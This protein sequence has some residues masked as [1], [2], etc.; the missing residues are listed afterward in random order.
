MRFHLAQRLSLALAALKAASAATVYLAGDS[1]MTANGNNDGTAGWGKFLSDY[2]SLTVVNNAIAGRSARSFT[3][4]GRFTAMAANVKAGDY[5]VIEFGHNDG[6]SLTPT[7]NGRT[8]CAVGAAGYATTCTSVFGGV[9]ETVL[10]YE[11]Y[12]VNA[13]KL[14]QA[15]GAS[16][17]ISTAT[18]DNPWETG[19]FT[20]A[21][22]RFV[23]Y[24]Q[25]AATATGATFVDHGLYTAALFQK[26]GATVVDS[27]YPID[28]THT[29]PAGATVVARAFILALEAT[30]STLK[31]FITHD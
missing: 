23:T 2:E 16:V 1:T 22:N 19:T 14:F 31:N 21:A 11:A 24:C 28:H 29:S 26:A 12:L 4:E 15:K 27:Y 18:P 9:T 25:D 3:R 7:D 30:N 8:D 6:G 10:T 20:Y 13:A 17:I 5:V